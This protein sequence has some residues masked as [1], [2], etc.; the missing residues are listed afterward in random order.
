MGVEAL[1]CKGC[2]ATLKPS[3][4]V[5][6]CE[7]CG[8]VNIITGEIGRQIDQLTQSKKPFHGMTVAKQNNGSG[9]NHER[10]CDRWLVAVGRVV[11]DK[12]EASADMVHRKLHITYG[13]A[14]VLIDQLEELGVV[15]AAEGTNPRKVLMKMSEWEQKA[16]SLEHYSKLKEEYDPYLVLAGKIATSE[17]N[18]SA[19]MFQRRLKN[20]GYDRAVRIT[21][22]LEKLGVIGPDNGI[23]RRKVLMEPEDFENLLAKLY[24]K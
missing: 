12:K 7:Y 19:S 20:I 21:N 14:A 4:T 18:A 15:S 8:T 3:S 2:G 13:E 17:K 22:T 1:V 5:C 11:I 23:D 24:S 10:Y 6:E 16:Y 9:D